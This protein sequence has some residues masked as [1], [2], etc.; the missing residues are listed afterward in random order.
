MSS[1]PTDRVVSIIELLSARSTPVTSADLADALGLS[2]STTGSILGTLQQRGWVSRLPDLRYEIGPG[3]ASIAGRAR[4]AL[5][6][7]DDASAHLE[8]LASRVRCGAALGLVDGTELIF[9]A[10]TDGLGHIPAGIDVGVRLPLQAPGGASVVAFSDPAAQRR[11]LDTA[12]PDRREQYADLLKQVAATGVAVWGA[13]AADL[14]RIDVLAQVVTHLAANAANQ[15]L[16]EQVQALI[17]DTSGYPYTVDALGSRESL[18]IS[19]LTTPVFDASGT[20]RWELQIGPLRSAVT[21]DERRTYVDE[22]T[23]T[24]KA[25]SQP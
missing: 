19:Y 17:G 1:P 18:P 23:A 15:R 20:P 24:A 21:P 14:D 3:L 5:D 16:R 9:V 6:L 4:S 11:W 8:A 22:L 25:M 12:P 2:R 10:M 13:D 7:P